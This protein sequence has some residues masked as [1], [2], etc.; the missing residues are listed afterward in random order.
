MIGFVKDAGAG[1]GFAEGA[2]A[3][4]EVLKG[5]GIGPADVVKRPGVAEVAKLAGIVLAG[6]VKGAGVGPAGAAKDVG[7]GTE[8]ECMRVEWKLGFLIC[9]ASSS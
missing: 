4:V 6:V 8:L 9:F 3:G 7:I 1:I 2:G 5:V